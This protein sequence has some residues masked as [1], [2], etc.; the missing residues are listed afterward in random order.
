MK[1][2]LIL[3][4]SGILSLL[5]MSGGEA[6][7][8]SS[9]L[10]SF[11]TIANR[12]KVKEAAYINRELS[13]EA[14]Q[15]FVFGGSR[16]GIEVISGTLWLSENGRAFT[17][18][19][20]HAGNLGGPE[21]TWN[22]GMAAMEDSASLHVYQHAEDPRVQSS[23][24]R[25]FR[26]SE[27]PRGN[28]VVVTGEGFGA[29]P[30]Y[31]PFDT[32]GRDPGTLAPAK[33]WDLVARVSLPTTTHT[34][35]PVPGTTQLRYSWNNDREGYSSLVIVVNSQWEYLPVRWQTIHRSGAVEHE[36]EITYRRTSE[37]GNETVG[38]STI[39]GQS[40]PVK[41]GGRNIACTTNFQVLED[42]PYAGD[43]AVSAENFAD[44]SRAQVAT[45]AN[46][47]SIQ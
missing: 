47:A 30:A 25:S 23:G 28:P 8:L 18:R 16:S 7:D 22:G 10:P 40:Y 21:V 12:W 43:L 35:E 32:D 45:A 31:S 15:E 41:F 42:R 29:L 26:K 1:R 20:G 9:P 46:G 5:L 6:Q 14:T 11:D 27:L 38:V 33:L 44:W 19:Q 13:F 2:A 37:S 36:Q 3:S 4:K 17:L 34:V 24:P 39:V